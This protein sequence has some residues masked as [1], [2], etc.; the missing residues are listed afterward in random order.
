VPRAPRAGGLI[1]F[2]GGAAAAGLAAEHLAAIEQGVRDQLAS[3]IVAGYPFVGVTVTLLGASSS[4]TEPS[5]AAFRAAAATAVR[6]GVRK[7]R[8]VLFEPLMNVTIVTPESYLGAINGDLARRRGVVQSLEESPSAKII[9][10]RVPLAEMFSYATTLRSISQGR[11]TYTM[12]LA[13]Y[14]EVPAQLRQFVIKD[15]AA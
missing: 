10:A 8:P 4:E 15:R 9:R 12:E 1:R 13:E 5:E 2:V 7:A 6:E 14:A 11:A 3:G